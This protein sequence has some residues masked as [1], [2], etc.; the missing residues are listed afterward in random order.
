MNAVL[1]DTPGGAALHDPRLLDSVPDGLFDPQWWAGRGRLL[2]PAGE[3]RGTVFFVAGD[4]GE[5]ALRHYQR[6]GFVGRVVNDRYLWAGAERTRSFREWRLLRAL[7]E[8]GLPVPQPVAARYQRKGRRYTADLITVRIPG[9]DPLSARLVAGPLAPSEWQRV[10]RCIRAFHD[11]SVFHADLNAHNV[12]LDAEGSPWLLD[13]DR[14][15]IR[16]DRGWRR[17]NLE[18]F[19]R[20]LNKI[21]AA[22]PRIVFGEREWAG[23]MEGYRQGSL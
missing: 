17:S 18:R 5:W 7:Y 13:F 8:T 12:L 1:S 16:E 10:G 9:A 19:L 14:G 2:G 22:D 15:R 20:S 6:G 3:G 11:A 23:V 4:R 21:R